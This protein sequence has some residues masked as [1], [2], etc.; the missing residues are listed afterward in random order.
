MVGYLGLHGLVRL[1]D[2]LDVVYPLERWA[3]FIYI[4]IISATRR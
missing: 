3:L 4:S 2:D 1:E